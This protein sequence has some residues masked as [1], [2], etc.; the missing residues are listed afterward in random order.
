MFAST[1]WTVLGALCLTAL[2]WLGLAPRS[3]RACAPAPPEGYDVTIAG[4]E[5]VI[6]WDAERKLEHFIRRADFET[7]AEGFGFIVPT[8]SPPELAEADNGLF[9]NLQ[10]RTRPRVVTRRKTSGIEFG[11]LFWAMT[12][13]GAKAGEAGVQVLRHQMVGGYD[14]VVL[15]ADDP[16]ALVK[17]LGDNGYQSSDSLTAW[18]EP[19]V[20]QGWT[21]TAFKLARPEGQSGL[22]TSAVRMT[23]ATERAVYPYREPKA[24]REGELPPE[25]MLR[26]FFI[27][28]GRYQGTLE[29]GGAWAGETIVAQPLAADDIERFLPGLL[30]KSPYLTIFFDHSNPRPPDVELYFDRAPD[31]AEVHPEPVVRTVTKP[32]LIPLE[33]VLLVVGVGAVVFVFVRRRRRRS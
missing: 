28:E 2:C 3:T 18:A 10:W 29:G 31:D 8:P 27:A 6:V 30:P 25:R 5:A 19:Y 32:L 33:L 12:A 4:E 13:D 9:G 20:E 7:E 21:F 16:A 1:R 22:S 24:Q 15:A 14:A 11:S 17:W 26:V 23:F